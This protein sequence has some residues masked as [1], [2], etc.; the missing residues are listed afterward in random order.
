LAALAL[1][2]GLFLLS[3]CNGFSFFNRNGSSHTLMPSCGGGDC[4]GPSCPDCVGSSYPDS[5]GS[6]CPGC[7]GGGP[8][9]SFDGGPMLSPEAGPFAPTGNPIMEPT[10]VAGA[11]NLV[12][13]PLA[14][15]M[16]YN[17]GH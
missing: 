6:S 16:P 15:R 2:G 11:P 10:P 7:G 5:M 1:T 3:G 9:M 8:P 13:T 17:P 14:P 4:M 12:P